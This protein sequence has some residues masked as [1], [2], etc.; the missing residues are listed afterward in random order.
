M[1]MVSIHEAA[2]GRN[3]F[4]CELGKLALKDAGGHDI[5]MEAMKSCII[6]GGCL[7]D[8]PK[9]YMGTILLEKNRWQSRVPSYRVSEWLERF[10]ADGIDGIELWENHALLSAGEPEAIQAGALPVA[11]YNMYADFSDES[12][13][14]LEKAAGMVRQFKPWGV[15]FNF[16]SDSQL[17][18]EYR[19]NML[20]FAAAIPPSCVMLCEVH[21]GTV[22]E[23][24][25]V[26]AAFFKDLPKERYQIIVHA[27][28]EDTA[29]VQRQ[30]D[31]FG[32]RVSLVHVQFCVNDVRMCLD[33]DA[34]VACE[35]IRIMQASGF[36]GA[37]TLEFT[38]GTATP[39]ENIE[40]MYANAMRDMR[41]I[42]E[43]WR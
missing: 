18:P 11:V 31:V 27:F 17:M 28:T 33:S 30:F 8:M 22:L 2:G 9:F 25:D 16:G 19:K 43:N 5:I 26:A 41:F 1:Y 14:E 10:A 36:K 20:A 32:D 7:K 40:D 12:A 38:E 39:N 15:K 6:K 37:F 34:E 35:C 13:A 24:P 4:V 29:S 3:G 21:Q 23:D 42:K